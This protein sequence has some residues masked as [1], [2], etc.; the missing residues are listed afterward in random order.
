M[1]TFVDLAFKWTRCGRSRR[2][3]STT[4]AKTNRP[5][6]V[7]QEQARRVPCGADLA[8]VAWVAWARI[9]LLVDTAAEILAQALDTSV[10]EAGLRVLGAGWWTVVVT[11]KSSPSRHPLA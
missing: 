1:F 9:D 2:D 8:V 10:A 5:G 11:E 3:G 4:M 6:Q 7:W